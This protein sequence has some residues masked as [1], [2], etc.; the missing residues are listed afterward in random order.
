M[1]NDM[2]HRVKFC[3]YFGAASIAIIAVYR[4]NPAK[5]F[6]Y[7]PCPFRTLTGFYCPG[8]GSLRA[9][10]QLLHGNLLAGF[11]LNLLMMLSLPIMGYALIANIIYFVR[12]YPLPRIFVP[13][14]WIWILL[15]VILLFWVLRNVPLYPFLL[16][17]P[18]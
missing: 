14:I 3:L 15:I 13:A 16:L 2:S 18:H 17:A 5:S 6:F 7:P 9:V 11:R 12:G 1:L 4:F 8:C 10:H